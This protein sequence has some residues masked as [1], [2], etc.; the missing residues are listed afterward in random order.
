M[1]QGN[2][3]L[4]ICDVLPIQRAIPVLPVKISEGSSLEAIKRS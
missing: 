1:T 3:K 4:R 2:A